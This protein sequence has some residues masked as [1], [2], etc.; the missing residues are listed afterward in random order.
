MLKVQLKGF[1]S[2]GT[3]E[4][5]DYVQSLKAIQENDY[6]PIVKRHL[7]LYNASVNG[8]SEKLSVNWNPV[9]VPGEKEKAEIRMLTSQ[10]D[11][12]LISSGVIS[13]EEARERM[14]NDAD[15]LYTSLPPELPEMELED[16][17]ENG[18]FTVHPGDTPK[19]TA[20]RPYTGANLIS[21]DK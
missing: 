15:S 17:D 6:T 5:Q 12:I 2:A 16:P 11:V 9:D 1:D 4:M 7:A 10:R 20:T 14:R 13:S 19:A 3:Y 21:K 18:N 8:V